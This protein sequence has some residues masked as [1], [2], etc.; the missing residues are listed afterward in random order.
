L[1]LNDFIIK[2]DWFLDENG[3]LVR[4]TGIEDR[5]KF[6]FTKTCPLIM[7][8]KD[9]TSD[10][11]LRIYENE[12]LNSVKFFGFQECKRLATGHVTRESRLAQGLAY[13]T[14]WSENFPECF[15]KTRFLILPTEQYIDILY[16]DNC[17]KDSSFW[18]QFKFYYRTIKDLKEA[19][20]STL[21]K[22]ST[23]V[24]ALLMEYK[25]RINTTHF[26]INPELNFKDVVTNILENCEKE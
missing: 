18:M 13:I 3:S 14:D 24:K 1:E 16:L 19:T 17:F 21:Y 26:E 6:A 11:L 20:P 2:R 25:S 10:G 4:E 12:E 22:N 15:D 8:A 5:Y 9:D 23:A 7:G